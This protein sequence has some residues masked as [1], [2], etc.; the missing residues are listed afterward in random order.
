MHK[1]SCNKSIDIE[2]NGYRICICY[3]DSGG[4]IYWMFS[5][6]YDVVKQTFIILNLSS[7]IDRGPFFDYNP[8][9]LTRNACDI[10]ISYIQFILVLQ[11]QIGELQMK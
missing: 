10:L 8:I 9:Q 5:R 6:C 7:T 11:P 2:G 4:K 1:I 3:E